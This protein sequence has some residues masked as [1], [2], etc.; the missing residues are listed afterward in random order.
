MS[1]YNGFST[2]KQ[3]TSYNKHLYSLIFLVQ[4]SLTKILNSGVELKGV[5]DEEVFYKY[6]TKI[7]EKV[8]HAEQY[9]YLP[10]KY[11]MAFVDLAKYY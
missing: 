2:R 1:V 9:K 3:E 4:N 6:F 11:G 5:F 8:T 7:Y 10:P